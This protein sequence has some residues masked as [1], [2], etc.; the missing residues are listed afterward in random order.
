[1]S[2]WRNWT[3]HW[4][5]LSPFFLGPLG[6]IGRRRVLR[7]WRALVHQ[8]R[9][10]KELESC[11]QDLGTCEESRRNEQR[12]TRYAMVA[13]KEITTAAELVKDAASAGRLTTS[14]PS[15][16]GRGNSPSRSTRSPRTRKSPPDLL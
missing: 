9:L 14:E 12:A 10:L 2:D 8:T 1:M 7:P 6:W 4:P 16:T 5:W 15:R 13:L 3:D 11:R